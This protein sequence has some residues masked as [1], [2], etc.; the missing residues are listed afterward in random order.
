M[1]ELEN[2]DIIDNTNLG[3][4]EN[5]E[6]STNLDVSTESIN[7]NIDVQSSSEI[8]NN[9]DINQKFNM[10]NTSSVVMPEEQKVTNITNEVPK[11]E[12]L[13]NEIGIVKDA[14]ADVVTIEVTSDLAFEKNLIDHHV[15]FNLPSNK[16]I[17]GILT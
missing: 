13:P 17:V 3:E 12:V 10:S 14:G 16:K 1:E 2:I 15:I 4:K 8:S 6:G 5:E 11:R 7:D 9:A